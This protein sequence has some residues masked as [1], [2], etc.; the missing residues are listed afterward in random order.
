MNGDRERKP[1]IQKNGTAQLRQSARSIA[2]FLE[3]LGVS[4][5]KAP[6]KAV[7]W[8][9]EQAPPEAVAGFLRGLFDADGC[10][11]DGTKYQYV[12][13]GS[14]SPELL[15]GVQRLLSTFGICSRMYNLQTAA[16]RSFTY[17]RNDGTSCISTKRR[18]A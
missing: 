14:A 11:Y 5:S 16:K 13:L 2:R 10:V 17:T 15:K 18:C 3:A 6:D 9:V 8:A 7:P 4:H 1:S 12:G